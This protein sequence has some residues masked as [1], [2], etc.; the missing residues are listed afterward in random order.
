MKTLLGSLRRQLA[1]AERKSARLAE[2]RSAL[3]A[4]SSRARVTTANARWARAAEERDR[5]A[6]VVAEAEAEAHR[7]L[8]YVRPDGRTEVECRDRSQ[9]PDIIAARSRQG[10]KIVGIFKTDLEATAAL[11]PAPSQEEQA[12]VLVGGLAASV[13]LCGKRVA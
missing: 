12:E 3:P 2:A 10:C 8:A 9:I 5:L 7:W 6:R 13:A 11:R 1:A 4:G